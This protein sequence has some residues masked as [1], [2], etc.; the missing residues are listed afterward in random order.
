MYTPANITKSMHIDGT[1]ATYGG[2]GYV[3][4]LDKYGSE[5]T[6]TPIQAIL[7]LKNAL[8]MDKITRAIFLEFTVYNGNVNLFCIFK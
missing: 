5:L 1:L 7:A 6:S 4:V 3:K 2:G 8:W